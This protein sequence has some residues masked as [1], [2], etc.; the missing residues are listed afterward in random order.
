MSTIRRRHPGTVARSGAPR[1]QRLD[2]VLRLPLRSPLT[3]ELQIV[4]AAAARLH[5]LR[6]DLEAVPVCTTATTSEAGAYRY[7]RSDPIDLRISRATGRAG[8]AFLH[9]LGHFVDHQL[10]YDPETRAWASSWHPAFAGWRAAVAELP[11]PVFQ[12]ADGFRRAFHSVRELWAR[13]YA[14]TVLACSSDAALGARL[15]ALQRAEDPFVWSARAFEPVALEVIA[16]F[17]RLEIAHAKSA[18]AA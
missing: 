3:C 11:R 16:V 12:T 9:E 1:L 15:A 17:E 10:G 4:L 6:S 8:D 13:C 5:H 18:L 14:Q 2:E 7:L